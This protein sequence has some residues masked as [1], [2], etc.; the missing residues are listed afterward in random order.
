MYRSLFEIVPETNVFAIPMS[1]TINVLEMFFWPFSLAAWIVL[2]LIT[3]LLEILSIFYPKLFRNDPTLLIIC[4]FERYN[5]HTAG[6][7]E[8]LIF[9]SM[10][11][12]FFLMT[13]AY[14][15]MIISFMIE[16]PSISKIRTIQELINSGLQLAAQKVSKIALYN[17]PRF[18]GMLLD[19]SNHSVDDFDGKSAFYGTL[20]YM[21]DRIR[22][23]I[24]Y[25]Y[26]RRR[27]TY[28]ILDETYGMVVCLYWMPWFDSLMEMFYYTERIFFEAGLL[29]KWYRDDTGNFSAFQIQLLPRRDLNFADFEDRLG[30][31]DMLPAWIAIGIGLAVSL[32]VLSGEYVLFRC[33]N[34]WKSVKWSPDQIRGAD[35]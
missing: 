15:T 14:E 35:E 18:S 32:L 33:F 13:N 4:G 16:K 12:F 10:I 28:Y 9:L 5:L 34:C 11:I 23:P 17:D 30:F 22:M 1:R 20:S 3:A 7:K 6:A 24:N 21:E 31:G 27:P 29:S 25:D 8:K 19:I 2:A 26:K